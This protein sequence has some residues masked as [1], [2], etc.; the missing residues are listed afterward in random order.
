MEPATDRVERH[1]QT[2]FD[3]VVSLVGRVLFGGFFI[4]NGLNHFMN[5][6]GMA[7]YAMS[8][9]L[10]MASFMVAASGLLLLLGGLS[11]LLGFWTRIGAWLLVLFLVP[12]AFLMHDYWAVADPQAASGEQV[13]FLKNM[14]LTG[15]ALMISIVPRWPLSLDARRTR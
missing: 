6:E 13:Q 5:L 3:A 11:I 7:G 2:T 8:K 14:A 4:Y 9:G 10:P 12:T 1:P 15:A